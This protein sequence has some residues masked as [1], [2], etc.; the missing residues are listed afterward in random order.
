[1]WDI[2][3]KAQGRTITRLDG[4]STIEDLITVWIE[5]GPKV[6]ANYIDHI[7]QRTDLSRDTKLKD[8]IN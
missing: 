5:A 4:N 1:M 2:W 8:L 6:R 3:M 7:E